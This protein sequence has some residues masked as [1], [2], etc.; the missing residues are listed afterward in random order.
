MSD[1]SVAC[2]TVMAPCCLPV[3]KRSK[4]A[5]AGA[6]ANFG[7]RAVYPRES[8]Q[9][10]CP[11][12]MIKRSQLR[13][14]VSSPRQLEESMR[15]LVWTTL[16]LSLLSGTPASAEDCEAKA[17]EI[18]GRLGLDAGARTSDNSIALT[19]RTDE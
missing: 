17:A 11:N 13:F 1:A 9:K 10:C 4:S 15:S 18:A 3:I 16:L 19:A 2:V 8:G 5:R 6:I 12:R 14:A 7:Q